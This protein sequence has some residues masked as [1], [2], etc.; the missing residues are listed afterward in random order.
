MP[1][2]NN[3]APLCRIR[4]TVL[5]WHLLWH[6]EETISRLPP[7]PKH[8]SHNNLTLIVHS[9]KHPHPTGILTSTTMQT[10]FADSHSHSQQPHRIQTQKIVCV[11]VFGWTG[12][13]VDGWMAEWW[14]VRQHWTCKCMSLCWRGGRLIYLAWSCMAEEIRS[15]FSISPNGKGPPVW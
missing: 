13:C 8:E 6:V 15:A 14:W 9:N 11:C 5:T 12:E 7:P 2:A 4:L 10:K 1:R 3:V